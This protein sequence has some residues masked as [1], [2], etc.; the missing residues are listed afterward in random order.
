MINSKIS[1]ENLIEIVKAGGS[2]KTGVDVYNGKGMLLLGRDILVNKVRTLEIVKEN[3]I[4]S[5]PVNSAMDGGLWDGNGNVIKVSSEGILELDD[6][7]PDLDSVFETEDDFLS[8][9]VE[10]ASP[11]EKKLRE[12]QAIKK[13]AVKKYDNAKLSIQKVLTQIKE[14]GGEFD[15]EE[16]ETNVSDLVKFLVVADNPFS[17]L[18]QEIFSYDNYLYNHSINVCTIGTAIL[19]QFNDHFSRR[20]DAFLTGASADLNNPFEKNTLHEI[21]SYSCYYEDDL[22]DISL[23]FFLHDMGKIL[24]PD[25]ILNKP[26]KLTDHEFEEIKK[27][28]YEY[29]MTIIE[30]NNLKNSYIKNIVKFHHA[31]L[32]QDE[33]RCYPDTRKYKEIPIYARICKLADIYD[34]MTSKRCYKEAFNQI[35]VVTELFRKYAKKDTV[36]QYILH[37][38]VKSIGIYPPG[39]IIY[40]RN[41]QMAYVLDSK[42]P[43]VLPFTDTQGQTLIRKPDPIDIGDPGTAPIHKADN[44]RSVKT[45]KQVYGLLPS[46]MKSIIN[47][48]GN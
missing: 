33:E 8:P 47:P 17:Y 19:H 24:V 29:G 42:G 13:I 32:Y 21:S 15:Y 27:H 41:G 44:R 5:V 22:A 20:I 25:H 34:A 2:V 36:L 18:T 38:F 30:K 16:V 12:I 31:P 9:P 39:S 10:P 23:G 4:S 45:P 11:I 6:P 37:S 3:G 48:T 26:D 7:L 14:T 1:I 35:N 46:F 43:I 40:L 28:S